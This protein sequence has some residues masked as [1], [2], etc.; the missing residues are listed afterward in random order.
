MKKTLFRY[1]VKF[2]AATLDRCYIAEV[3]AA[4]VNDVVVVVVAV[5]DDVAAVAVDVVTAIGSVL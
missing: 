4:V 3:D 1:L 5:V 2:V